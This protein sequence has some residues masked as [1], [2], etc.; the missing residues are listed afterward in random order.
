MSSQNIIIRKTIGK[1]EYKYKIITAGSQFALPVGI[2]VT[3]TFACFP[4]EYKA[5]MH[6]IVVGRIDGLTEF[7]RDSNLQV[8]YKIAISY[9]YVY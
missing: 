2:P 7:Y 4:K 6:S 5:K 3:I 1:T 8:G 9:N